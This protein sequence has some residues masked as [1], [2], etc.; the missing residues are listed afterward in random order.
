MAHWAAHHS[1]AT[2]I[3]HIYP[4]LM[5]PMCEAPK[6]TAKGL[7][8][9]Y[10]QVFVS[11]DSRPWFIWGRLKLP[12]NAHPPAYPSGCE[13]HHQKDLN[14]FTGWWFEPLWKIWKSIG[15]IIPIY[16]KIKNAPNHQPDLKQ[17]RLRMSKV[18]KRCPNSATLRCDMVC[19][20]ETNHIPTP[21]RLGGN[22]PLTSA[23]A[24]L[25]WIFFVREHPI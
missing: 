15:M 22:C 17:Y 18:A 8:V 1:R 14:T 2:S 6:M 20:G 5:S 12:V 21:P 3:S 23:E 4:Y 11:A 16:G 10:P 25:T 13:R 7:S 9:F 24:S 19:S